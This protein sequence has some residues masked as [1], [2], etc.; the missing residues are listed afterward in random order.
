[1]NLIYIPL[2]TDKDLY[3]T[4]RKEVPWV[5][6][7]A[8]RDECFMALHP[9]SKYTYGRGVGVRTYLSAPMDLNVL[10]LMEKLNDEFDCKYNVCVLNY[11]KDQ[12]QHLGWH[13]DDSPEQDL[14]HPIAVISFGA[15]RY[16]YVKRQDFKGEVPSH[17]KFLLSNGS[18]F[19]MPGGYQKDHYHKIPKH[20]KECGGTIWLT[21][22]RRFFLLQKKK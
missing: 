7:D 6:R 14:D 21:F 19:V 16:I 13:A 10:G 20:D 3:E 17:N 2:Y 1:M 22:K 15:E 18:L 9:E 8:P 4:L 5:N 11:Y 12:H